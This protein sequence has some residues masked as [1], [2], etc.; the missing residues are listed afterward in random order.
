MIKVGYKASAEQFGPRELLKFS[1][2]AE[3]LGFD[4]VFVSDHF[5]PWKHIDGHAP[6]SL[7]WL[8]ALGAQTSRVLIGTSVLTPT[9]RYHPSLVAQAFATLG[10]M[11]PG[12]VILGV[13]TGESLNEVPAMGIAWPEFKERFARLREAIDLIRRLWRDER[14]T[15]EGTYY[16]TV[17]ATVYDRPETPVPIYVAAAGALV[18]KYAGR[19]GDG[20]ITTSGKAPALYRETLL[21][22]LKAGLEAANR[23]DTIDKMIEM[24]VSYDTDI[25]RAMEDTREWAALALTPEQKMHVEDPIEMQRLAET[26]SAEQAA[27]RWIVSTDPDEQVERMGPYVDQG[28]RHLVFHAP[29]RDQ[30]RFLRLYAKDVLPRLRAKFG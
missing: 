29:G 24:K 10:A 16:R 1:V 22:N 9:F 7:A 30:E 27:T 25:K 6:Q 18:A 2:L 17:N 19:T 23:P 5:Q 12:R 14:V 3:E 28:F 8:G 13:G 4:S 20:F 21:P 26:L 15:F 11:F